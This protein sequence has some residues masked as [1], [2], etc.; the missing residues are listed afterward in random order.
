MLSTPFLFREIEKKLNLPINY[1]CEN[2]NSSTFKNI[3]Y[4][5]MIKFLIMLEIECTSNRVHL[6]SWRMDGFERDGTKE[7]EIFGQ[8]G[9]WMN[10]KK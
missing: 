3:L 6:E 10:S 5:M 8:F 9:Q 2:K 7:I 1:Q 4:F